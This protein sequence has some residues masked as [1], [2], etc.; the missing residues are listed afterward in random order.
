M[1]TIESLTRR[2]AGFTAVDNVSF[3]AQPGRAPARV[4]GSRGHRPATDRPLQSSS[5]YLLGATTTLVVTW[6]E[7]PDQARPGT[8]RGAGQFFG[9]VRAAGEDN[10]DEAFSS[11]PEWLGRRY[12][13][14]ADRPPLNERCCCVRSGCG[15][16]SSLIILQ[17]PG[18]SVPRDNRHAPWGQR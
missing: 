1:I 5:G 3:T 9:S 6:T 7:G 18:S 8:D 14:Q 10:K 16:G 11:C 4:A 15:S 2:Y 13:R 12:P 17:P